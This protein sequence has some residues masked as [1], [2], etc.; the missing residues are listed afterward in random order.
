MIIVNTLPLTHLICTGIVQE[1]LLHIRN[2]I[3]INKEFN[4]IEAEGLLP[5]LHYKI[6]FFFIDIN[7]T[8]VSI[9]IGC[10]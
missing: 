3:I 9:D 4:A 6:F 2:G 8:L 7:T 5:K 1:N 10:L